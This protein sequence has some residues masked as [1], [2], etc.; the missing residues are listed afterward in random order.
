LFR[1]AGVQLFIMSF[2]PD[3]QLDELKLFGSEVA[4]HF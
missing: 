3:R 4:K 2:E 1:D